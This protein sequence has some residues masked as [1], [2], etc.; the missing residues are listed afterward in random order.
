MRQRDA[1]RIN[2]RRASVRRAY[3]SVFWGSV[4]GHCGAVLLLA[5]ERHHVRLQ[6]MVFDAGW[7]LLKGN[8][9]M[10]PN[11]E[12]DAE[13]YIRKQCGALPI[14]DGFA[15]N[16]RPQT[17]ANTRVHPSPRNRPARVRGDGS[18]L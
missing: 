14:L 13:L 3:L 8:I 11:C 15:P 10:H 1:V 18:C 7:S 12:Y 4:L 6:V 17:F 5:L 2:L 16:L 9:A